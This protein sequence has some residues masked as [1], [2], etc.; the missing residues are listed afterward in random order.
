MS[1]DSIFTEHVHHPLV[2][3][4]YSVFWASVCHGIVTL[5][6]LASRLSVCPSVTLRYFDRIGWNSSKMVSRLF[7]LGCLL[8]NTVYGNL[9]GRY[10]HWICLAWSCD[11]DLLSLDLQTVRQVTFPSHKTYAY[12]MHTHASPLTVYILAVKDF[13]VIWK[14][15]T[16]LTAT[17][18]MARCLSAIDHF[19][20]SI[21]EAQLTMSTANKFW[22]IVSWPIDVKL[23]YLYRC[24][25]KYVCCIR[26][27][28][29]PFVLKIQVTKNRQTTEGVN[30]NA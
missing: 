16:T 5:N 19:V 20:S 1:K 8:S 2:S 29:R 28:L 7:S 30:L 22:L 25:R 13:Y 4:T 11:P 9:R 14:Q 21:S 23:R 3:C 6:L 12:A 10:F 24:Y 27:L 26:I 18:K 15:W 17:L